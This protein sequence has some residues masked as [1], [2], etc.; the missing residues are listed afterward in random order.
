MSLL[1]CG[2]KK[3]EDYPLTL[4]LMSIPEGI[5]CELREHSLKGMIPRSLSIL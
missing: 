1:F 3:L 4:Q 2:L 5:S